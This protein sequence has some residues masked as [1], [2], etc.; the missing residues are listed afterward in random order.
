[1]GYRTEAVFKKSA[2]KKLGRIG[3]AACVHVIRLADPLRTFRMRPEPDAPKGLHQLIC[4]YPLALQRIPNGL[5]YLL[6]VNDST[7]LLG[8]I[9]LNVDSLQ[10]AC[11]LYTVIIGPLLFQGAGATEYTI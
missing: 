11:T 1:M 3:A 2:G 8:W 4:H 10:G 6:W 5:T 7:D 9:K